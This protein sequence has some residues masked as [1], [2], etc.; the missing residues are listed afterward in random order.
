MVVED[1]IGVPP[2]LLNFTNKF[3]VWK[4]VQNIDLHNIPYSNEPDLAA[5][6]DVFEVPPTYKH[7]RRNLIKVLMQ[8]SQTL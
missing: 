5:S 8:E 1:E 4:L 6:E 7:V 3:C 2:R